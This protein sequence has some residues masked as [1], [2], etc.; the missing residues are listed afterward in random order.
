MSSL[1]IKGGIPLKGEITSVPN[2]NSVLKIIPACVLTDGPVTISNVPRSSS[3]RVMLRIFRG[4]GG[5]VAYLGKGK[6]RLDATGVKKSVIPVELAEKERASVMF[7]GPL[8]ARFGKAA[9]STSGGCKLGNRPLDAM[10][11]GLKALGVKIDTDKGY[12]LS[13]RK[14][15][16]NE[17]IWLIEASVTGTENL[18]LAAV[19]ASGK[20]IIYNAASEPHTQ[21]LCKFLTSLG[22][23]I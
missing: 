21:N 11:Q 7:L 2:K 17:N 20:T 1:K 8:L 18:I 5:K 15:K 19:K 9:I 12:K 6:I 16:G 13:T 14:L 23:R 10:F 3:V 4:L 22:A